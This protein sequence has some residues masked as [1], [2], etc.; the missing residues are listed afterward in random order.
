[1]SSSPRGS[2]ILDIEKFVNK[3]E[4]ASLYAVVSDETLFRCP[5]IRFK[6]GDK[7]M[8]TYSRIPMYGFGEPFSVQTG[9]F[10][11][12][13]IKTWPTPSEIDNLKRKVLDEFEFVPTRVL[14]EKF[15]HK[16]RPAQHHSPENVA[17]FF[18]KRGSSKVVVNLGCYFKCLSFEKIVNPPVI[19]ISMMN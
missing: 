5:K 1:M 19:V 16:I 11:H 9:E 8:S 2:Q 12:Q 6:D 4:L 18:L 15:E 17:M 3:D 14:V 10:S 7:I 13:L